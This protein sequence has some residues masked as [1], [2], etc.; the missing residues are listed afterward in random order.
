MSAFTL[1]LTLGQI[2][3]ISVIFHARKHPLGLLALH[4]EWVSLVHLLTSP[5]S[6]QADS[7]FGFKG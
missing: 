6:Q 1:A 7:Y 3:I 2:F 5:M 4:R